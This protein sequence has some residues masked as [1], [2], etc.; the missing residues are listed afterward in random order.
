MV[1]EYEAQK[2]IHDM[3]DELQVT[4]GVAFRYIAGGLVFFG[5]ALAGLLTDEPRDVARDAAAAAIPPAI[6][7]QERAPD[8]RLEESLVAQCAAAL[9]Y[10]IVEEGQRCI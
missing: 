9:G 1:T 4:P 3:R 6:L 7:H 10:R 2:L 8:T 5:F